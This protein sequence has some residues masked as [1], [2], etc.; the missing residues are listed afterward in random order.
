MDTSATFSTA[1]AID[2][3]GVLIVYPCNIGCSPCILD[4]RGISY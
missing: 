4:C 2:I 1:P 3:A